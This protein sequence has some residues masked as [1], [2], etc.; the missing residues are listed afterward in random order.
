VTRAKVLEGQ[1]DDSDL[2]FRELRLIQESFVP[3]LTSAMH[4]RI[5]YPDE[6]RRGEGRSDR[7]GLLAKSSE[8][9]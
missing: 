6:V 2:T 4:P 8:A 3:I 7:G 9:D 1:L 5:R